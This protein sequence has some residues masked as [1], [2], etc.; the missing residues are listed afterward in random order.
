MKQLLDDHRPIE[1]GEYPDFICSLGS[2]RKIG[3][4]KDTILL[5][6]KQER[7][8]AGYAHEQRLKDLQDLETRIM[9]GER[10]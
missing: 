5:W 10:K 4:N 6:I 7:D 8:R 2:Y 9:E 3:Y 1:Q